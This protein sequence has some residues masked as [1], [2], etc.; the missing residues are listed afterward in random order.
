MTL[1]FQFEV[2]CIT[3]IWCLDYSMNHN[4]FKIPQ[5]K[6]IRQVRR[7]G[8]GGGIAVFLQESLTINIRHDVSVNNGDIE[9]LCVESIIKK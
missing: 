5:Y 1:K 6:S 7:T 8:K 3:E 2:L 9:A 4:L